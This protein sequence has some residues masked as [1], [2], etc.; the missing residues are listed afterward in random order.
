[1]E[2]DAYGAGTSTAYGFGMGPYGIP[3]ASQQ[4]QARNGGEEPVN[5][6]DELD[7]EN[8]DSNMVYDTTSDSADD[9]AEFELALAEDA[10]IHAAQALIQGQ[11]LGQTPA[12]AAAALSMPPPPPPQQ[13]QHQPARTQLSST[14]ATAAAA[15]SAG[16]ISR[17]ENGKRIYTF[18]DAVAYG[19]LLERIYYA[20]AGTGNDEAEEKVIKQRQQVLDALFGLLAY[21]DPGM[22]PSQYLMHDKFREELAEEL[23]DACLKSTDRQPFPALERMF[24]QTEVF[25][26]SLRLKG[27]VGSVVNVREDYLPKQ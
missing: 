2:I 4:H 16:Q 15:F 20:D 24:Q 23:N 1:M 11:A 21:R 27:G 13:Q 17:E 12:A 8:N 22:A 26:R 14:T 3:N 25:L 19:A 18:K 10:G 7:D 9:E 5:D 6:D